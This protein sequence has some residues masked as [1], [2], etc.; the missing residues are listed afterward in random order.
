MYKIKEEHPDKPIK[1][2][3][4][5]KKILEEWQ[6]GEVE[7]SK[8]LTLQP[9]EEFR[10]LF[11]H[12]KMKP[13]EKVLNGKRVQRFQYVVTDK[14]GQEKYWEVSRRTSEQIN[15]F[16]SKGHTLLKIQRFGSGIDT[17]YN[18]FPA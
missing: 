6:N 14:T 1:L 5:A 7:A 4:K 15:A 12:E 10:K 9:G 16:L 17:R 2:S 13:A 8:F 11:D 3:E 18:I